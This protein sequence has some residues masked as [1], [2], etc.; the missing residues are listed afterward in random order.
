MAAMNH[1]TVD[2]IAAIRR[3]DALR[4]AKILGAE[5]RFLDQHNQNMQES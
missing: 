5:L 2:E 1:L 4:G 3:N